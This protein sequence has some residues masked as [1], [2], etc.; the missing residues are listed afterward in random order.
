MNIAKA[1]FSRMNNHVLLLTLTCLLAT[2]ATAQ[3]NYAVSGSTAYVTNSPGA[4]GNIVVA[5]TY[6]GYPVTSIGN[7]AFVGC[8]SLTSVTIPDSVTSIGGGAF[9]NCGLTNVTIGSSVT[10]IGDSAFEGCAGLMNVTIG[11]SVTSIG[12]YAFQSCTSVTNF[13]VSAANSVY[14]SLDGVLLNKAQTTLIQFPCGRGGSYAIPNSVTSVGEYAF[15]SCAGLT[16]LTIP[17]SVT[18][19][20]DFAF[21]S[22][23]L[24]SVMI[25]NG[26]TS[27]GDY[28]FSSCTSLTNL[29]FLGNAPSLGVYMFDGDTAGAMVYYY[30]GTTGWGPTYG[31]LPTVMLGGPAPQVGA[32]SAG[33]KA[34][35]FGFTLNGVTNQTIVV[36]ASTNLVNWQPIW[37]STLSTLSTNF[38]DPDWVNHPRRFYRLRSN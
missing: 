21:A 20:G 14:S 15:Y 33:V 6:N 4:S 31:G 22:S 38:V 35:G 29:T 3:V 37:T 2:S 19:L 26:V 13:S 12:D 34:G 27:I 16:S 10:S 8:T 7:F 25:G 23:G 24:T 11:N 32:S 1:I 5:S 9:S 28:A 17:N 30:Y 18:S 36:E